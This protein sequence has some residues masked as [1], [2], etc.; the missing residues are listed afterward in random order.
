GRATLDMLG[1]YGVDAGA[2]ALVEPGTDPAPLA[3]GSETERPRLLSVAALTPG[4][5]HDCL[6]RALGRLRAHGWTLTC[7]G[8]LTRRPDTVDMLR[9]MLSAEGIADRVVLAGE[10]VGADLDA[11]YDAADVFV[12]ATRRETYGMAVAEALAR[13]LPIVST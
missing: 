12:L 5:G 13:G 9:G 8:S 10:L 7:A 11:C 3:R 2:V 1:R 6:F 4:K